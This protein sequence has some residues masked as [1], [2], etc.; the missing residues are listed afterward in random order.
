M[1][2]VQSTPAT[3]TFLLYIQKKVPRRIKVKTEKAMYAEKLGVDGS[4]D[5]K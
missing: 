3:F 4:G 1:G 5:L 2:L